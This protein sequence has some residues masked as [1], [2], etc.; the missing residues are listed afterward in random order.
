MNPEI[1]KVANAFERSIRNEAAA[2]VREWP[3]DIEG[4]DAL[5]EL[6]QFML[7]DEEKYMSL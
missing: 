3:G 1:E 7:T 4:R 5:I 2:A 6:I